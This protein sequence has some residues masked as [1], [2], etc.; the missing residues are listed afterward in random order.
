MERTVRLLQS[1]VQHQEHLVLELQ[2]Q[3]Q[4]DSL[5]AAEAAAVKY[6][7]VPLQ[8]DLEVV[9]LLENQQVLQLLQI[10]AAAEAAVTL[11]EVVTVA[12]VTADLE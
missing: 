6:L 4:E 11:E 10:Q 9:E 1:W 5:A 8:E 3:R 2:D 12:A 7:L